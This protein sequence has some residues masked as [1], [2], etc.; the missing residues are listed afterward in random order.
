VNGEIGDREFGI[1]PLGAIDAVLADRGI[2]DWNKL[3]SVPP[4][5][6]GRWLN[7][8]TIVYGEILAHEAYWASLVSFWRVRARVRM[9]LT[10]DGQEVFTAESH[11]YNVHVAPTL[12]PIDIVILVKE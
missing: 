9:V 10:F 8:D 2:D 12:D 5:E 4:E 1:V 7:A 6:L 3:M 11:R